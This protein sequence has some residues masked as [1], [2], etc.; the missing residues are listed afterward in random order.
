MWSTR[1]P[2]RIW[3]L[4]GGRLTGRPP[5]GWKR[6][7]WIKI[8]TI[9][10][11]IAQRW[12]QTCFGLSRVSFRVCKIRFVCNLRDFRCWQFT[13]LLIHLEFSEAPGHPHNNIRCISPPAVKYND[14]V[15]LEFYFSTLTIGHCYYSSCKPLDTV[16]DFNRNWVQNLTNKLNFYQKKCAKPKL[17]SQDFSNNVMKCNEI[18]F[19]SG[20]G[21]F[22]EV[23][24]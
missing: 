20:W 11:L 5:K 23:C 3:M 9:W 4:V 10:G 12:A 24:F 13:L 15:F 17:T 18:Q 1:L 16:A 14:N 7:E 8:D 21:Q 19:K 2:R 6:M 22:S